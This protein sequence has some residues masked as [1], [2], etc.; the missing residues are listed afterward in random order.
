M[1]IETASR[2]K[3]ILFE[4]NG[5]ELPCRIKYFSSIMLHYAE[6]FNNYHLLYIPTSHN[7][8]IYICIS[9]K[10]TYNTKKKVHYIQIKKKKLKLSI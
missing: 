7:A 8:P 10:F 5:N 6:N 1:K 3:Y 9:K 2:T 4:N